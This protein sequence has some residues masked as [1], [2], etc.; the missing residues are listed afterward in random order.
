MLYYIVLAL[1]SLTGYSKKWKEFLLECNEILL[2]KRSIDG[3]NKKIERFQIYYSHHRDES[4]F[5][6]FM[7]A[8]TSV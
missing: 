3:E 7:F 2:F 5:F 8:N 1:C 4:L 6:R